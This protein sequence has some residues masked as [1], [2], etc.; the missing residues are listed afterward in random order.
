MINAELKPHQTLY[1]TLG[2]G[3]MSSDESDTEWRQEGRRGP[4]DQRYIVIRK[5]WLSDELRVLNRRVDQV[6]LEYKRATFL[7]GSLPHV[8]R[9][10]VGVSISERLVAGLPR[11]VYNARWLAAQRPDIVAQLQIDETPYPFSTP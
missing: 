10:G 11:N 7:K 3:G 2:V 8:R 5:P 6:I 9:P 1:E 4:G